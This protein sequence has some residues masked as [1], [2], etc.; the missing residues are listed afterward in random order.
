MK[1]TATTPIITA[2]EYRSMA[3][4]LE[5]LKAKESWRGKIPTQDGFSKEEKEALNVM[6]FAL[7]K[8]VMLPKGTDLTAFPA[9]VM[10]RLY[11]KAYSWDSK[12]ANKA[13][14]GRMIMDFRESIDT[15]VG[16][17][18]SE[19]GGFKKYLDEV[20][21]T[22]PD[23]AVKVYKA[24]RCIATFVE[25]EELEDKL[26]PDTL[27]ETRQQVHADIGKFADLPHFMEVVQGIGEYS[28]MK[29][30]IRTIS[31]SRYTF[32]WQGY[33]TSVRCSILTHM[34]ESA[35]IS[36]MSNLELGHEENILKDFWV[37]MFHDVAEI[38]TDDI[39]SPLKDGVKI[40]HPTPELVK[41]LGR[42]DNITLR[43][44]AE[45]QELDALEEKFY[46]NLPQCVAEFFRRGVMLEDVH[47]MEKKRF[48]KSA[49]YF[50][51][52]L[53]VYWM[54]KGGSREHRFH[55][56]LVKSAE[57]QNRTEAERELVKMLIKEC[58]QITFF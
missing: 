19:T 53:E 31:A 11:T 2:T 51:A 12:P 6:T 52:D 47:D 3:H 9:Y 29:S 45:L 17:Q 18:M 41:R 46:L 22:L 50:S 28:R 57:E 36:F 34:L 1:R 40:L 5:G 8:E 25:F 30:L 20:A 44:V 37:L 35:L 33:I 15:Y 49:D 56:I 43:D 14:F 42:S 10:R 55:D 58:F 23:E 32:R 54:I 16:E 7:I 4:M 38:W 13:Y 48:Y 26:R 39:P 24:A 27:E 21:S